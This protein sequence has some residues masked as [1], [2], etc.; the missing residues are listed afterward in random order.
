VKIIIDTNVFV[1]G[2]FFTGPPHEILNAW[3]NGRFTIVVSSEILAE[4]TEVGRRLSSEYPGT[5]LSRALSLVAV[6]AETISA[7]SLK[8]PV[9]EDPNDD[10]FF[11]CAVASGTQV[12][13]SGDRHLHRASGYRGIEVLSPRQFLDRFIVQ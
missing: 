12:I 7:P 2:V 9:C 3:R 4:Y 13:V 1:S 8:E 5:S 11:A 6:E 10:M